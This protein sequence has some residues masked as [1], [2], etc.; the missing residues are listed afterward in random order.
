MLYAPATDTA[1]GA[2]SGD[3]YIGIQNK[4]G[5]WP[6]E[7]IMMRVHI[8]INGLSCYIT[9]SSHCLQNWGCG[10]ARAREPDH[11]ILANCYFCAVSKGK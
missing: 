1:A 6:S 2:V 10:A 9:K 11:W 8:A 4:G 3:A 7:Y 5:T